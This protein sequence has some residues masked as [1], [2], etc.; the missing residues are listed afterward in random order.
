MNQYLLLL[1]EFL[2]LALFYSA[3]CRALPLTKKTRV[4]IRLLTVLIASV[5]CLGMAAPV[6]WGYVPE[7]Y[8]VTNLAVWVISQGLLAQH[9][10]DSLDSF[11]KPETKEMQCVTEHSSSS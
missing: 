7:W 8:E 4:S 6:A 9:W 1:H 11:R 10:H 2:C 5:A 3:F